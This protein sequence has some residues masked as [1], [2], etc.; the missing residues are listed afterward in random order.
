[1]KNSPIYT[2]Y[3]ENKK[4]NNEIIGKYGIKAVEGASLVYNTN[5]VTVP[6]KGTATVIVN[7]NLGNSFKKLDDTMANY[8]D[9]IETALD[10]SGSILYSEVEW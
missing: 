7:V 9:R 3:T 2:D 1:M 4:S 8:I 5:S 6:A 10:S